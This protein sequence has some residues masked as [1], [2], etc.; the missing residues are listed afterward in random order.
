MALKAA[1]FGLCVLVNVVAA[2]ALDRELRRRLGASDGTSG[3]APG[4]REPFFDAAYFFLVVTEMYPVLAAAAVVHALLLDRRSR[5][6][7]LTLGAS[8]VF[9]VLFGLITREILMAIPGG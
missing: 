9:S 3:K 8:L 5:G 2:T 6:A 1:I 4:L 7:A